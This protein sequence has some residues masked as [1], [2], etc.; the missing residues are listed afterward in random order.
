MTQH[1]SLPSLLGKKK[2]KKCTVSKK[3]NIFLLGGLE[4]PMQIKNLL[5]RHDKPN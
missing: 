3:K 2:L 4:Q 5:C 1:G